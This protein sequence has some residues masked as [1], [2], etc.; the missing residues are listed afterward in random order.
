MISGGSKCVITIAIDN[1]MH[2]SAC[3]LP[4]TAM[5][6]V[7]KILAMLARIIYS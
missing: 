6:I 1:F 3:K 4:K 2:R 5:N 7:N